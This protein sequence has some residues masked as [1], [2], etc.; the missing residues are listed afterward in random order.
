MCV[1]VFGRLFGIVVEFDKKKKSLLER[2]DKG[3][4]KILDRFFFKKINLVG[5]LE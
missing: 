5:C 2:N 3:Q 1:Y 4:G